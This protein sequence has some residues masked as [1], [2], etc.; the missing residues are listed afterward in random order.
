LPQLLHYCILAIL[1]KQFQAFQG[2][3]SV[4]LEKVP[5]SAP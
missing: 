1:S 4:P 2:V 3:T 5:P